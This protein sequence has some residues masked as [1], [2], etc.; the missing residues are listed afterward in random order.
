MKQKHEVYALAAAWH[1]CRARQI[2]VGMPTSSLE[3]YNDDKTMDTGSSD[4]KA[5]ATMPVHA[6]L[7]MEQAHAHFTAIMVEE[8]LTFAPM[9]AWNTITLFLL[10]QHR[11]AEGQLYDECGSKESMAATVA[12]KPNFIAE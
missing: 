7:T 4:E 9:S 12:T 10:E 11:L 6:G 1:S 5:L 2:E 3:V 8:Q